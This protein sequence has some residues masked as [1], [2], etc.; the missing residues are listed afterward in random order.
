MIKSLPF[1]KKN[2]NI[3]AVFELDLLLTKL[4]Y[5]GDSEID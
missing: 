4:F 3:Y 2:T 5:L 1:Q